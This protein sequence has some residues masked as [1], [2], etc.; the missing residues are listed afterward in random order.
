M[1]KLLKCIAPLVGGAALAVVWTTACADAIVAESDLRSTPFAN[2]TY[3]LGV[4]SGK[5][6]L[7]A[8]AR[9]GTT[10]VV[11]HLEGL[12]PGT[13]HIGH[14]HNGDCERLFPGVILHNLEPIIANTDGVGVSKTIIPEGL[15]GIED[16]EWW[17]AFHEG[18][19]NADPQTPA[20]AIGPVLLRG[21]H[22][23]R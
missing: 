4:I 16:C 8:D 17:V 22:Q 23:G 7:V 1:K 5:A 19:E 13:G 18:P 2:S 3:G 12:T 20:I 9:G 10:K 21:K 15:A 14:I 11:A 6:H